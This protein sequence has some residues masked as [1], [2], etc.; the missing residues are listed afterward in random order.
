ML[1]YGDAEPYGLCLHIGP[2]GGT[3][4]NIGIG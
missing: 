1:F 2:S 3:C 4:T